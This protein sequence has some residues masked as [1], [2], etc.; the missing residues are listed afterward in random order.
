MTKTPTPAPTPRP[1]VHCDSVS[2]GAAPHDISEP[3]SEEGY[4]IFAVDAD[5]DL[6]VDV[7]AA[8]DNEDFVA[9]YTR[10][11]VSDDVTL[12]RQVIDA[13]A[14][15][16]R[17]ICAADVDGDNDL[18]LVATYQHTVA[19][20]END[21]S[22]SFH[23]RILD[24]TVLNAYAGWAGDLDGDATV[25]VVAVSAYNNQVLWFK[26]VEGD[27]SL[28]MKYA[29]ATAIDKPYAA[30]PID[31]DGDDVLDIFTASN[32]DD[33]VAW[34]LN[35]GGTEFAENLV[36]TRLL[37]ARSVH[38]EDLTGDGY[39]DCLAAGAEEGAVMLYVHQPTDGSFVDR[40]LDDEA[41]GAWKVSAD[42][43][44]GQRARAERF[45]RQG[46]R[47]GPRVL[48]FRGRRRGSAGPFPAPTTVRR[49]VSAG[50][51]AAGPFRTGPRRRPR[52]AGAA[53]GPVPTGF[54]P[55]RFRDAVFF[56]PQATAPST[57]S[58]RYATRTSWCGFRPTRRTTT[59]AGGRGR[60]ST[61]TRTASWTSSPSTW[62]KTATSTWWRRSRTTASCGTGGRVEN[63]SSM[64]AFAMYFER[65]ASAVQRC[66]HE[67]ERCPGTAEMRVGRP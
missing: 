28:F 18:D 40:Y 59:W 17:T 34:W 16:A 60:A 30:Y 57:R 43:L 45:I 8:S 52:S 38:A 10:G 11:G 58:P 4:G 15:R 64:L 62:T 65:T 37:G 48:R 63:A 47:A 3:T 44:D 26:N 42:D 32:D 2:F 9:I 36:S 51:A 5:G 55:R 61:S 33:T 27:G 7:L 46:G 41:S 29:V 13:A 12:T 14:E 53:A 1:T 31:A 56:S 39:V 25:D 22:L 20:Y 23:K 21:G 66:K 19:W 49:C 54:R 24:S 67:Q 35:D 50:A 6:D